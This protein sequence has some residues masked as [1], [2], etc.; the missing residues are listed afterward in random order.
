MID[1][2]PLTAVSARRL[3]EIVEDPMSFDFVHLE[4]FIELTDISSS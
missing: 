2:F 4:Y 1:G 3:N